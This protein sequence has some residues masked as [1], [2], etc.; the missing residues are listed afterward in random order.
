MEM[1]PEEA[2]AFAVTFLE[3]DPD[4]DALCKEL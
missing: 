1:T 3:T 2:L 4:D